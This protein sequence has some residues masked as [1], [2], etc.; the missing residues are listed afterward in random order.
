MP[1]H[2]V[3]LGTPRRRAEGLRIG[4]VRRPPRGVHRSD[5]A[6]LD[7]YDVWFPNLSPT[8]DL[9]KEAFAA[10]DAA[11]LARF[12]R[13]F[14]AEMN[15][16]DRSRELDVLAALSHHSNFSLGCYCEDENRCHR[17]VL[18]ELLKERGADVV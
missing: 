8:P 7:Y 2:I 16:P 15:H 3:Q 14:R 11:A 17:S 12:K 5:F 13:K 10:H 18:R 4:T 1:I 9:I 6:K